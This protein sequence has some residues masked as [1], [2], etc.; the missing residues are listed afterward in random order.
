MADD[1]LALDAPESTLLP[2][3]PGQRVYDRRQV[4]NGL[5]YIVATAGQ[6]QYVPHDFMP[7]ATVY[8]QARRR[9]RRST[10]SRHC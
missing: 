5:G 8:Q 4:F 7:W 3:D 9:C 6:W 2:E 10:P 1:E